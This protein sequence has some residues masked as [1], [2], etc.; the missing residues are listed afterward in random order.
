MNDFIEQSNNKNLKNYKCSTN[1]IETTEYYYTIMAF[2]EEKCIFYIDENIE[3]MLRWL[4]DFI[5]NHCKI[6]HIFFIG[7][8]LG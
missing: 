3:H 2:F 7:E 1:N 8:M 5:I 6:S 4:F